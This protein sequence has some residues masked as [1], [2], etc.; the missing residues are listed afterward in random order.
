M[1]VE[2]GKMFVKLAQALGNAAAPITGKAA[3]DTNNKGK[4]TLNEFINWWLKILDK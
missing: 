3:T 4:L 2:G 1:G